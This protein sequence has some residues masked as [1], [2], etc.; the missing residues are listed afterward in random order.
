M[1]YV[2][3]ITP[4]NSFS[5]AIRLHQFMI[6]RLCLVAEHMPEGAST[7]LENTK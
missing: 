7:Q 5:Y 4:K 3:H 2:R 1:S 6:V